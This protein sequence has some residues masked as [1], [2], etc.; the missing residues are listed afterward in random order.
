MGNLNKISKNKTKVLPVILC[1]GHGTRLWPLSRKSYPKQFLSIINLNKKSLLQNTQ[2]RLKGIKDLLEPILICNSEHRFIVAEQMRGINITPKSILLEP[3]RRNTAPAILFAA[4]KSLETENNPHLLILSADHQINNESKFRES[5]EIGKIYSRD[6][7]LVTFG[8]IPKSPETGYGYIKSQKPFNKKNLKGIK[9]SEFIEKPDLNKAKDLMKDSCFSWNSGI[10]MFKAKTIIQ[11]IKNLSPK[12]FEACEKTYFGSKKDL[13]FHRFNVD[14][15]KMCPNISID[16]AV[17]EKTKRGIVVPLDAEWSDI[18]SWK[19]VWENSEKESNGTVCT[20]KVFSEKTENCY[21]HSKDKL[22]VTLGVKDLIVVNTDDAT[23]VAHQN[24]SEN[25]RKIVQE[26]QNKNFNEASLHKKVYRP[27]GFYLSI[28]DAKNWQ[29]K[30]IHV[31]PGAKLSLQIHH[32]RS[33]H[34]IVVKGVA[35]VEINNEKKILSENEST[36]IPLG[37]KHRITNQGKIPLEII[38]VKSGSYVGEDDIFRFEDLYGR[39]Y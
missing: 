19:S 8:V 27:W 35:E 17:M 21:L 9:I 20:G 11:E 29:V 36:F 13:D 39:K 25:I 7:K 10:F 2:Q 1:G 28:L 33:E 30:I 32:Y 15:F 16:N 5:V 14:Y 18:G 3:F 22:L 23:L 38:E 4:F 6:D 26:L 12:V 31:K 37:S 24:E 34:W